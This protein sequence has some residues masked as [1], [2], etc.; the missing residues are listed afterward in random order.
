MG[1]GTASKAICAVKEKVIGK[2]TGTT[3][4]AGS[5]GS[6]NTSKFPSDGTCIVRKATS[7]GTG[8]ARKARCDNMEVGTKVVGPR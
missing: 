6:C 5:D 3:S 2:C 1:T 8:T 7:L 4:K